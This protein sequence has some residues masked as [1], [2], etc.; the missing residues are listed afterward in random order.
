MLTVLITVRVNLQRRSI[1]RCVQRMDMAFGELQ[2]KLGGP[3]SGDLNTQPMIT[4]T[5]KEERASWGRGKRLLL[6]RW[7]GEQMERQVRLKL[8]ASSGAESAT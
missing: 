7:T 1:S 2:N 4:M 5:V 8:E 6:W 3:P